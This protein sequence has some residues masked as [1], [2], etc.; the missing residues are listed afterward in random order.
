M[1]AE[2]IRLRPCKWCGE[3]T[4]SPGQ[5]CSRLCTEEYYGEDFRADEDRRPDLDYEEAE[6]EFQEEDF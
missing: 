2:P 4:S 3:T 5:L 1:N 6:S